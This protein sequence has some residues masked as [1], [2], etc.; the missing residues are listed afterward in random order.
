MSRLI[1]LPRVLR[2]VG[3]LADALM[4]LADLDYMI[5]GRSIRISPLTTALLRPDG[6]AM[7]DRITQYD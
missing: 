1:R 7:R 4:G 3:P 6:R 5:Q 2:I